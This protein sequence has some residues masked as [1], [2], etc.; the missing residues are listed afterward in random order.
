MRRLWEKKLKSIRRKK[1]CSSKLNY[2]LFIMINEE[3][4]HNTEILGNLLD[5]DII[6]TEGNKHTES[7]E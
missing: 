2:W 3:V 5:L 6:E 1:Y 7:N 4:Q